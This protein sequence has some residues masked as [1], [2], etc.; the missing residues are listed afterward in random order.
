M[1]DNMSEEDVWELWE[2]GKEYHTLISAF[3]LELYIPDMLDCAYRSRGSH[4]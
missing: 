1:S 2:D 4:S 3:Q